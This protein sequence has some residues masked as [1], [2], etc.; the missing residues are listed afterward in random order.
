MPKPKDKT[1]EEVTKAPFIVDATAKN[2]RLT[3]ARLGPRDLATVKQA[4]RA[5]RLQAVRTA[6]QDDFKCE[7]AIAALQ[8]A[9]HSPVTDD[10][11]NDFL[12]SPIGIYFTA[13]MSLTKAGMTL[14][15]SQVEELDLPIELWQEIFNWLWNTG[16]SNGNF[17]KEKKQED[18]GEKDS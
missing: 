1:L 16:D 18:T 14:T 3:F 10:E 15:I 4:I 12:S 2:P 11:V 7:G 13:H 8:I 9:M 17:T 6:F 5:D